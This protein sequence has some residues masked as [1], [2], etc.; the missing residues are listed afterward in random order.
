MMNLRNRTILVIASG[1]L[2]IVIVFSLFS[3][4]FL[5]MRFRYLEDENCQT[6]IDQITKEIHTDFQVMDAVLIGYSSWNKTYQF[7]NDRNDKYIADNLGP[8]LYQLSK[9]D[10]IILLNRSGDLVFGKEYNSSSGE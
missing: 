5:D 1:F 8:D 6:Y 2:I 4:L 9:T 10:I 7:A 3:S